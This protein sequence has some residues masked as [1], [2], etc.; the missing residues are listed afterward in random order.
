MGHKLVDE[1]KAL[2]GLGLAFVESFW[3]GCPDYRVG[4]WIIVDFLGTGCAT[5]DILPEGFSIGLAEQPGF[6]ID[7][8]TGMLPVFEHVHSGLV[9]QALFE[10]HRQE[11]RL[12]DLEHP[13]VCSKGQI[14]K[15]VV[16]GEPTFQNKNMPMRVESSKFTKR[17]VADNTSAKQ[18]PPCS[19][20]E[21]VGQ[22]RENQLGHFAKQALIRFKVGSENLGDRKNKLPM[23]QIQQQV[24]SQVLSV[25]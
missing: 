16:R 5:N 12:P 14:Y 20:G 22:Q 25:E 21:K 8:K 24:L 9:D 7:T 19:K 1:F 23:R 18:C 4:S 13:I 15:T 6:A 11:R 3:G 10:K 17:L 2:E